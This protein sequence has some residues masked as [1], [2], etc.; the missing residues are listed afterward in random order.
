MIK[1]YTQNVSNLR[2]IL[3]EKF[4]NKTLGLAQH[5]NVDGGIILTNQLLAFC[6]SAI[7]KNKQKILK[8]FD[9]FLF[10]NSYENWVNY[11]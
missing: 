1:E 3:N 9:L 8:D 10:I 4:N 2:F 5:M 6:N 7:F 11:Q